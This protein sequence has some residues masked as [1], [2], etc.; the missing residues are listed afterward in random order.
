MIMYGR[1]CVMPWELD[2]NLGP[3]E[4]EENR[5]LPIEEVIGC[6][7]SGNRSLMLQL[8]T[9]KEHKRLR[10]GPTMP[11]NAEMHLKWVKKYGGRIHSGMLNRNC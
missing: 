7:T 8:P 5:D 4:N 1:P 11:N 2:G 9:S 6:T 3:L 10:Q